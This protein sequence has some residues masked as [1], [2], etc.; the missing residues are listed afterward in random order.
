L[1]FGILVWIWPLAHYS[2]WVADF[3]VPLPTYSQAIGRMKMG[4]YADAE[5]AII[6]QLEKCASDFDGW[7]MLAELYANQFHDLAEAELT[8]CSV[9]DEPTTTPSQMAIAMHRL[10]DW[11]LKMRGDP[12]AARRILEELCRRLEG[13]HL[14]TMARLRINQLPASAKELHEQQKTRTFAM[15]VHMETFDIP[16]KTDVTPAGNGDPLAQANKLVEKLKEDPND[17]TAREKLARIFAEQMGQLDLAVE[18]LELL[19]GMPGQLPAKTAEWLGIMA[20]WITRERGEGDAVEKILERL[21]HEFPQTPQAFVA[22]RRLSMMKASA[23]IR[24]RQAA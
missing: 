9:C 8:I 15:P 14:A 11:Q 22:Q 4:K 20:E 19:I 3:S 7:M 16:Q 24:R 2:L 6:A 10:A 23:R 21:V 5:M 1:C 17:I 12:A 18:Q 13:T